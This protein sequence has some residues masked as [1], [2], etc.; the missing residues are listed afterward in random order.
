MPVTQKRVTVSIPIELADGL[1]YLARRMAVSK[2]A[3]VAELLKEVPELVEIVQGVPEQGATQ[4][5]VVR[6]RGRSLELVEARVG[7]VVRALKDA[8]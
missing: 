8:E 4:K 5:D 6:A 3:L 2:S 1:T 7:K